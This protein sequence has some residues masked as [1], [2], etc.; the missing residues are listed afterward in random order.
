MGNSNDKNLIRS[1]KILLII[2]IIIL[3]G[4]TISL[5]IKMKFETRSSDIANIIAVMILSLL[6]IVKATIGIIQIKKYGK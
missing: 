6:L 4:G 3:I 2:G 1:S 5:F